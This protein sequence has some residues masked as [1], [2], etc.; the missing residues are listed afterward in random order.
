MRKVELNPRFNGIIE[1][2]LLDGV[3][4]ALATQVGDAM[5]MSVALAKTRFR[6]GVALFA[7]IKGEYR[8]LTPKP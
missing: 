6:V 7:F 1:H 5:H 2:D 4:N 3:S 8:R